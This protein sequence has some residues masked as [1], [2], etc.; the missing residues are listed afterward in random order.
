[1]LTD[2][3][4]DLIA[5][6]IGPNVVSM[7]SYVSVCYFVKLKFVLFLIHDRWG[8]QGHARAMPGLLLLLEADSYTVTER[9]S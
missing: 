6:C 5:I 8:D 2:R 4:A 3:V 9:S 7:L 1:M